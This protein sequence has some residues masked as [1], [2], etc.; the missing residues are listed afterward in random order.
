MILD[1]ILSD[2]KA[3]RDL[4]SLAGNSVFEGYAERADLFERFDR[5]W[6]AHADMMEAYVKETFGADAQVEAARPHR[7]AAPCRNRSPGWCR[8]RRRR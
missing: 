3:G 7:R 6:T 4:F 8:S 5:L 2:H 1:I